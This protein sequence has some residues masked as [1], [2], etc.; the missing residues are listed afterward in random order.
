MAR[1][2]SINLAAAAL[3]LLAATTARSAIFY[4]YEASSPSVSFSANLSVNIYLRETLTFGSASALPTK[5]GLFGAGFRVT[6]IGG[7]TLPILGISGNA[8]L[9]SGPANGS[10]SP[11]TATYLQAVS[12]ETTSGLLTDPSG[13]ILLGTVLFGSA[14]SALPALFEISRID[15]LGGN[16]LTFTADDLDFPSPDFSGATTPTPL[17]IY[18][19]I[20]EPASLSLLPPALF[21]LLLRRRR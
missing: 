12:L 21:P 2:S 10:V 17:L 8:T 4:Q 11:T 5:G 9:F 15:S 1:S 18:S 7:G 16:T 6:H 19:T 13:R 20:P 14:P 3:T